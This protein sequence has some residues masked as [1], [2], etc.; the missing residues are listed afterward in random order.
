VRL[1]EPQTHGAD[2][3]LV[4]GGL[5]GESLADKGDLGDH[6]LPLLG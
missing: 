1:L 3:P 5:A 4:L 6:P 2:E